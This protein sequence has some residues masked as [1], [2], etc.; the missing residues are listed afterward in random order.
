MQMFPNSI[1]HQ[2]P[3]GALSQGRFR[4]RSGDECVRSRVGC[5]CVVQGRTAARRDGFSSG[6]LGGGDRPS[7]T[8]GPHCPIRR[9][10]AE[11]PFVNI[12]PGLSG[13]IINYYWLVAA[14]SGRPKRRRLVIVLS[15]F[16]V[17]LSSL[18]LPFPT[19]GLLPWSPVVLLITPSIYSRK[20][21]PAIFRQLQILGAKQQGPKAWPAFQKSRIHTHETTKVNA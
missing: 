5:H 20:A 16:T 18:L 11:T 17:V 10:M 21:R 8:W 7:T 13:L 3:G 4:N 19:L 14:C 12:W 6:N 1:I 2:L 15:G 9:P